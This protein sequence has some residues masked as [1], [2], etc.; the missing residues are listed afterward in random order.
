M[1]TTACLG[2]VGDF[3]D[4]AEP[5]IF[6]QHVSEY[7]ASG[8]PDEGR[9]VVSQNLYGIENCPQ[10]WWPSAPGAQGS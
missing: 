3:C 5:I 2:T 9:K 10:T 1:V 6:A 4:I 7:I 8:D